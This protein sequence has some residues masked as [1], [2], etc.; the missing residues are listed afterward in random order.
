MTTTEIQQIR[1][2]LSVGCDDTIRQP[3]GCT[4]LEWMARSCPSLAH[5]NEEVGRRLRKERA[6]DV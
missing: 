3:D 5:A 6:D 1:V 4:E 2:A